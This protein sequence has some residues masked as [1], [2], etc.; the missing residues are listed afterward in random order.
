MNCSRSRRQF[1]KSLG[2]IPAVALPVIRTSPLYAATAPVRM[3]IFFTPCGTIPDA[4]KPVGT[5]TDFSFA[6]GSILEPLTEFKP[7]L[8]V[9]QGVHY[10]SGRRGPGSAHQKGAGHCL[11]GRAMLPGNMAG[12]GGASAGYAGGISVD[13]YIASK[14]VTTMRFRTLELGVRVTGSGNRQRLSYLGANQPVPVESDPTRVWSRIFGVL[15]TGD[16]KTATRLLAESKSLVD[17]V[18]TEVNALSKRMPTDEKAR[19]DRHLESMRDLERQLVP[20]AS[21]GLIC[22][23]TP[24][25]PRIDPYSTTNYEAV[26]K[27]QMD[28]LAEALRCQQTRMATF[29]WNGS[30]SGQTFPWLGVSGGHHTLSHE[31]DSNTTVKNQ[32]IAVNKWYATQFAYLLRKLDV[33]DVDGRK[34]LDNSVVLWTN[35]LGKGNSHTLN[36]IPWVMAGGAGGY[37]RTGRYLQYSNQPHNNLLV[38]LM[39]AMGLPGE[40]TFGDPEFCTGPLKDLV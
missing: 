16:E 34:V 21:S 14:T 27:L 22:A 3:V 13:Q 20:P 26:A 40:R 32:L 30:T 31:P 33:E 9:M 17:Y 28:L 23:P 6:P 29:L 36:D 25:G 4:W 18:K 11:V 24:L 37:F 39:N 35:E 8:N 38:S 19:L 7:R 2:A 1:L 15:A 5:G 12:G 10:S